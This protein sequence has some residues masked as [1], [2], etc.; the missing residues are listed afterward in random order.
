MKAI[1]VEYSLMTRIIVPDDFNIDNMSDEDYKI[2]EQKVTPRFKN[3]LNTDG[4]GDLLNSIVEDQEMPFGT[5][6]DDEYFQPS[7]DDLSKVE[8][9]SSSEVFASKELAQKAFPEVEILTY[10]GDDIEGKT[11][12]DRFY[13]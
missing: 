11:F 10:H 5:A 4:V 13:F 9:L 3:K 1:L 2:L 7:F 6:P 12:V 8:N